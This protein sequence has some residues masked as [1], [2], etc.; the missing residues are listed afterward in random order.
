MHIYAIKPHSYAHNYAGLDLNA[1]TDQQQRR[2]ALVKIVRGQPVASQ[3]ELVKILRQNGFDATQSS[4]SRDLRE[5]GVAKGGDRYI[6][7]SPDAVVPQDLF[8][9]VAMFVRT[10]QPAGT[11]LTVIKT[12]T[13]TAQSV[14]LAI[15]RADWPEVVG[16]V[17]GDDTIFVAT[18]DAKAQRKLADR[19]QV[20]F[21]L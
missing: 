10:I 16:T 13:G 9:P 2:A 18:N 3:Q 5:L 1:N 21:K 14:A 20:I 4:V 19:L 15:D 6:I 8:T 12:A 17:S 11:N 7:P